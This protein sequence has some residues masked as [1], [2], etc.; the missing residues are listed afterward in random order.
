[1]ATT[2]S[3]DVGAR[4][5]DELLRR[6]GARRDDVRPVVVLARRLSRSASSRREPPDGAAIALIAR[7]AD[8]L[9]R[10]AVDHSWKRSHIGKIVDAIAETTGLPPDLIRLELQAR[11]ARDPRVI[12]LSPLVAMETELKS[13]YALTKA[14]HVSLWTA[15]AEGTR[16]SCVITV[17]PLKPARRERFVARAVLEH[18]TEQRSGDLRGIPV[19]RWQRAAAALVFAAG[20]ESAK[21]ALAA[22]SE[23]AAALTLVL[24]RETLMLRS[25]ARERALVEGGERLLARIGF[26]LHDGPI[27]DMAA[28]AGDTRLLQRQLQDTLSGGSERSPLVGR[29]DDLQA[30]IAAVD[31]GLRDIVHSL[32]APTVLRRPLDAVLRREIEAF[33]EQ[34]EV[35]VGLSLRGQF[36]NLSD[37][38]RIALT[39]IVQESL[40]NVREHSGA[41]EVSVTVTCTPEEIAAEITDNGRGFDVERTLVRTARNGRVGLLGMSERA[42]LLGGRFDIRSRRGGPTTVSIILPA[43]RPAAVPISPAVPADALSVG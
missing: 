5:L 40:T 38:Q 41:T 17:G 36:S 35:E 3:S 23:T 34:A 13:F 1:L 19:I 12:A 37:S 10:L 14:D 32:E 42:R 15:G 27:Q 30:R 25:A 43:W 4:R 7:I 6:L 28:L 11:V 22:A 20:E 31:R 33:G 2:P 39:R 18:A 21:L 26:D 24:E 9:G 29:I 8:L 16:E